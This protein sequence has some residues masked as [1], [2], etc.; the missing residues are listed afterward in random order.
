MPG[1]MGSLFVIAAL[2]LT[3]PPERATYD[4][5]PYYLQA[6]DL[7][8]SYRALK[9]NKLADAER[10]FRAALA[11]RARPFPIEPV[12][13]YLLGETLLRRAKK[14]SG[15]VRD[16]ILADRAK[17]LLPIAVYVALTGPINI[18]LASYAGCLGN[19]D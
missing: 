2:V 7:A 14:A 3:A 19:P 10:G 15:D 13:R 9:Q 11:A 5:A 1:C 18:A 17:L 16:A 6:E 12:L 8:T 4:F